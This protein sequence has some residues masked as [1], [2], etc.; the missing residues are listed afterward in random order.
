MTRSRVA[1]ATV[2]LFV[3]ALSGCGLFRGNRTTP[4]DSTSS[5]ASGSQSD[6]AGATPSDAGIPM[7]QLLKATRAAGGSA[8]KVTVSLTG[9]E[10][11][12]GI[13][14]GVLDLN[15]GEGRADFTRANGR[16]TERVITGGKTYTSTGTSW[17]VTSQTG[18]GLLGGDLPQLWELLAEQPS[19]SAGGSTQTYIDL[20]D[21][22]AL[23]GLDPTTT[24]N[25]RSRD[26][27]ALVTATYGNDDLI[28][29]VLISWAADGQALTIVV[30]IR[31]VGQ[32]V[33]VSPP[34]DVVSG[35]P[36]GQ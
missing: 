1:I 31:D 30:D 32:V 9:S 19:T 35:G 21:A 4:T 26:Q 36:E 5:S 17:V 25:L 12:S 27:R 29:Q 24:A 34:T 18:R 8:L 23:S 33:Q 7:A 14:D 3:L 2:V 10:T 11:S 22:L 20:A 16:T 15:T 28:D 13:L 6:T